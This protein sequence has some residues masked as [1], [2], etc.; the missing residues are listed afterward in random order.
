[1]NS[2][3]MIDR[4][5]KATTMVELLVVMILTG[6]VFLSVFDGLS[7]VRKYDGWLQTNLTEKSHTLYSHQLLE[8]LLGRAD[9]LV[10]RPPDEYTLYAEGEIFSEIIPE[11]HSL[12]VKQAMN[13]DTLFR[14]LLAVRFQEAETGEGSIDS[15]YLSLKIKTDTVTLSYGLHTLSSSF[16]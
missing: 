12:V 13:V 10:K 3:M 7:L 4:Q 1:M 2:R 15:L 16:R 6:I 11:P 14:N 9:S 8:A 5:V